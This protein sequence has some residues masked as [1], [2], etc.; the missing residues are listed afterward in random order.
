MAPHTNKAAYVNRH[1]YHSINVQYVFDAKE[2]II[3]IVANGPGSIHDSRLLRESGVKV[4]FEQNLV[5]GNCHLLGDR[6]Y[7]CKH[8]LLTPFL[9]PTPG[10]QEN[11]NR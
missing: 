5:P 9:R 11:Y 2:E 3:D 1:Y 7:P 4:R 6:G 10:H 8:W